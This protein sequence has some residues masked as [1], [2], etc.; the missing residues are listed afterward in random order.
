MTVTSVPA[1]SR[2][3]T[4]GV[5]VLAVALAAAG[6]TVAAFAA[7]AVGADPSFAPLTPPVYLSFAIVGTLVAVAG[8]VLVV[9]RVRRS[10][11]MLGILVPVLLV[12]SLIPDVIVLLTGFIPGTTVTGVVGLMLMHPIVV[13]AAV[14]AGRTIAPPR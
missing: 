1:A 2:W 14:L 5:T 13:G 10:A 4:A 9:R 11:R 3:R 7:L 8:W 6:T 12:L